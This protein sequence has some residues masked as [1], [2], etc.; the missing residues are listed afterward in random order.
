MII[1]DKNEVVL[2]LGFRTLMIPKRSRCSS[3]TLMNR[4]AIGK[5]RN[6]R[7]PEKGGEPQCGR[8][9]STGAIEIEYNERKGCRENAGHSYPNR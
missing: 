6:R 3:S 8:V 1:S 4:V 7:H 9:C 2:V 5:V